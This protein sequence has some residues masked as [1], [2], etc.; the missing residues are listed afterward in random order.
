MKIISFIQLHSIDKVFRI[1]RKF[2]RKKNWFKIISCWIITNSITLFPMLRRRGELQHFIDKNSCKR[3]FLNENFKS[4][5]N[6]KTKATLVYNTIYKI[7]TAETL[8]LDLNLNVLCNEYA[9]IIVHSNKISF[10]WWKKKIAN[11]KQ[12]WKRDFFFE[13]GF[14][15]S[16]ISALVFVL[17]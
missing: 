1:N 2:R 15:L 7:D 10:T 6:A 16:Q 11:N 13:C 3:Y 9:I 8:F 14:F 4:G 12:L 5:I 17:V